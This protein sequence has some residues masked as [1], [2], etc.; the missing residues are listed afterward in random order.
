MDRPFPYGLVVALVVIGSGTWSLDDGWARYGGLAAVI[1]LAIALA[2]QVQ[3][4]DRARAAD[5]RRA[6]EADSFEDGWEN[7]SG[8]AGGGPER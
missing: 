7:E 2:V 3:Q 8:E 4:R 1:I 6:E 5:R